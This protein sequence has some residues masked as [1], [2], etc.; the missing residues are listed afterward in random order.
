LRRWSEAGL[1][2]RTA[3]GWSTESGTTR[4]HR[5]VRKHLSSYLLRSAIVAVAYFLAAELGLGL[6]RVGDTVTPLWPPTG[7]ALVAFLGWGRK[8]WP[9]VTVAALA[10]NLPTG[11]T[12]PAVVA[13]AAGNTL[14][15]LAAATLL[16]RSGFHRQ[17]DRVRDAVALVGLGALG[18]MAVSATIGALALVALGPVGTESLLETWS[19]W[20]TGDAMGVLVVAPFLW[21]VAGLRPHRPSARAAA[22]AAVAVLLL[23]AT[24]ALVFSSAPP[25]GFLVV[26][27]LGA[28]AWRFG[29]P[30]AAPAALA[31]SVVATWAAAHDSGP[32]ADQNL[33]E[34]MVALQ[35]LNATVALTA[36]FVAAAVTQQKLA[37]AR[38]HDA[39]EVLQRSLLPNVPRELA[40]TAIAAR[41]LPAGPEVQV[42]GDWYDVI[43]LSGGRL[44]LA[45]GDVA[46]HGV[47]AAAFMGQ[48][49]M[50]LRV[51]A[52]ENLSPARALERLSRV[53]LDRQP[54]TIATLWYGQ[55]DPETG[56]LTFATAGHP[57]PLVIGANGRAHFVDELR[58]P[59]LGVRIGATYPEASCTLDSGTGLLLYT[60][61]LVEQRGVPIDI[62]LRYL[63]TTVEAGPTE[64]EELC[65]HVIRTL[66]GGEPRDDIA[67]LAVRSTS[68][69]A[70]IR[71]SRPASPSAA[72][73]TRKVMRAW[74]DHHGILRDDS[75]DVLVAAG[76]AF[77]NAVQHAYGVAGGTVEIEG[78]LERDLVQISVRDRGRWRPRATDGLGGRGIAVIRELMDSVEVDV[79][80]EGT[81]IRMT[82]RVARVGSS[83]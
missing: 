61:G 10:V 62:R 58:A 55:L 20:W 15:P 35:S 53:P 41:Y 9:A 75:F 81:V 80:G 33:L 76:E 64:L 16:E 54:P 26:P 72:P 47:S 79:N 19:V 59:P 12:A 78:A 60:D 31:V 17:L 2:G 43:P 65:D 36:I 8:L 23:A 74:L 18:S 57:P 5:P 49:R 30:G 11:P 24:G 34:K 37:A 68:V 71:L 14:A 69:G 4:H 32:F 6:A 25:L 63:R 39:V 44:G 45:V 29:Q 42:G 70:R 82:R 40:G 48:L 21:S 73:E 77:A 27:V 66:V 51:Y 38:E 3:A 13:I 52:R 46:G 56:R 28:I 67:L 1:P 50:A 83:G 7:V 22:E